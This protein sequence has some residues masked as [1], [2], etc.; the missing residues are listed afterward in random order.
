MFEVRRLGYDADL[1]Y[2]T[3]ADYNDGLANETPSWS[4]DAA[5]NRNDAS[6]VDNLNRATTIGGVARTYDILGNTL[7][8]GASKSM[9]WDALNRMTSLTSG[10]T[11]TNYAYRPD[12]MRV[13][14]DYG[15]DSSRFYYDGQMPMET[16][17]T[18]SSGS[19]VTRNGLGARGIDRIERVNSSGTTVGYPLY[20]GHGNMVA[21]L[22]KSGTSFS[23]GDQRAYDAWGVIRQGATSGDPKGRYCASLGHVDDDES[24]LT[25][26]R[27]RYYEATV[28]RFMSADTSK[29]GLN[30]FV[31]CLNNP[32]GKIDYSGNSAL[33]LSDAIIK[34]IWQNMQPLVFNLTVAGL[35]FGAGACLAAA[36][37]DYWAAGALAAASILSLASAALLAR[38]GYGLFA[39][40][41]K[42]NADRIQVCGGLFLLGNA[43][44]NLLGV[45]L[46]IS[47]GD[48]DDA[49]VFGF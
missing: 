22:A 38:M 35:V 10:A 44:L 12:G 47:T 26:M 46:G 40:G 43:G 41:L 20:D 30:W 15:T 31:Y 8:I 9:T 27:A 14:K 24:G 42:E 45:A 21:T 34:I 33:D 18:T 2:L 4:Y 25:Y 32:I 3:S 17:D 49:W 29:D 6:V 5:G 37:Q 36:E 13:S 11:T 28:G 7:T 16:L 19:T 23:L 1:D 48:E 39:H